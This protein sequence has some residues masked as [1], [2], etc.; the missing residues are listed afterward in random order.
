MFYFIGKNMK[1]VLMAMSTVEQ[2]VAE[3]DKLSLDEQ[4]ELFDQ[5]ADTLDLLGWFKLNE[6]TFY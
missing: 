2:L 3:I 5:L 4:K 1:G 6:V